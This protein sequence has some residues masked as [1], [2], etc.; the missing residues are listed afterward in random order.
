MYP[1][2]KSIIRSLTPRRIVNIARNVCSYLLSNA[3]RRVYVW[4]MPVFISVEPTSYCNLRCPE[5]A[6]G[7]KE[8]ERPN[9][10][11]TI[12]TFKSII[13]PI[14]KDTLG[15]LL[16][17]QGEPFLNKDIY[18]MISY[19]RQQGMY[20]IISTNGHYFTNP[21]KV[22]D[23]INSGL[24]AL[25]I[26]LDGITQESYAKYRVGGRLQTVLDGIECIIAARKASKNRLPRIYLQF[27]VSSYNEHQIDEAK[28]L[29][30]KLGADKIYFKTMQIFHAEGVSFLP[31]LRDYRRYD[32][33]N[34]KLH[35]TYGPVNK[36]LR[37]W[38]GAVVTWDGMVV[39]C[40]YDKKAEHAFGKVNGAVGIPEIWRSDAL[41]SLRQRVLKSSR[42]IPICVDCP[43]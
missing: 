6:C 29:A 41:R 27:L 13:S 40:C 26:S 5:C 24:N 11:Q 8:L 28:S 17:F 39:P 9:G 32:K 2:D 30:R 21:D 3:T 18:K 12:E 25:V 42:S 23:L 1:L 38:T 37:L 20:V 31:A 35:A 14:G 16:Y 4:G 34:G 7:T 10:F 43:G 36:C 33:N 22:K 15:L 19:A